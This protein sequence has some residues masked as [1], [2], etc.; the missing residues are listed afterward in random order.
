LR[1]TSA[2][3]STPRRGHYSSCTA[4]QTLARLGAEIKE[5]RIEPLEGRLDYSK[6]FS[7]I[8][9][10]EFKGDQYRS[11]ANATELFGPI[12]TNNI[13]VSSKVTKEQYE[14]RIRERPSIIA[15][16]KQ[17]FRD[18]DGLLTPALPTTAPLL[19]ASVGLRQ[20]AAIHHSIQL[21]GFA[22]GCR[23]LRLF[24]RRAANWSSS[25]G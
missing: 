9:L 12:V 14:T 19:K 10:Y 2:S 4:S 15:E 1:P 13:E 18:V 24:A 11:T 3:A 8:L 17:A 5:I 16:V 20:R 25:G 21:Y 23:S 7:A 6:L 22:V